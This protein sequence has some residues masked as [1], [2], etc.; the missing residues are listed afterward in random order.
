[1]KWENPTKT[2]ITKTDSRSNRNQAKSLN[3]DQ[4]SN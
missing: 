4:V 2:E 3:R 1:M